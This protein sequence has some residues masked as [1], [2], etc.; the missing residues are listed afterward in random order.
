MPDPQI[1]SGADQGGHQVQDLQMDGLGQDLDLSRGGGGSPSEDPVD[2]G[3]DLDPA[4]QR[5]RV[6]GRGRQGILRFPA[7]REGFCRS[8]IL[9]M[10]FRISRR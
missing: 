1:F 10:N 3:G 4:G 9:R 2:G 6:S 5:Q 8:W 7:G